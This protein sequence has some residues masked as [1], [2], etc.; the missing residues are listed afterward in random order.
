METFRSG[1]AFHDLLRRRPVEHG[2]D[3]SGIEAVG[4]SGAGDGDV[5]VVL[6]AEGDGEAVHLHRIVGVEVYFIVLRRCGGRRILA[7]QVFS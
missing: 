2:V 7:V 1:V 5:G 4:V 6:P 3:M